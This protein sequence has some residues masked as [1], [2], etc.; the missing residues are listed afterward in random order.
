MAR[1]RETVLPNFLLWIN[2]QQLLECNIS[3][4][5]SNGEWQASKSWSIFFCN[6]L[7]FLDFSSLILSTMYMM[8]FWVWCVHGHQIFQKTDM[9]HYVLHL[10]VVGWDGVDETCDV[11]GVKGLNVVQIFG[12]ELCI[13]KKK[14]CL[15]QIAR[16]LRFLLRLVFMMLDIMWR[17]A[18]ISVSALS[19][20]HGIKTFKCSSDYT[21]HD[22][23]G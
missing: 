18:L 12:E 16:S 14:K 13:V 15:C 10:C 22:G 3:S 6:T 5:S 17:S 11:I 21:E 8:A 7:N 20:P 4:I 19:Y 2:F 9:I 1:G 23:F